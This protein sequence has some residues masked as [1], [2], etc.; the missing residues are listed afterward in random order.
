MN[1]H[2]EPRYPAANMASQP[3]QWQPQALTLRVRAFASLMILDAVCVVLGFALTGWLRGVLLGGTEG[4]VV[5]SALLPINFLSRLVCTPMMRRTC[6]VRAT[7]HY[8]AD[9]RC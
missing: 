4:V 2:S 9:K 3:A 5:V 6:R 7:R 1:H 8:V